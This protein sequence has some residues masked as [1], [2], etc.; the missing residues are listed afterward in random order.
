[1]IILHSFI[2]QHYQYIKSHENSLYFKVLFIAAQQPNNT[3]QYNNKTNKSQFLTLELKDFNI[4][5]TLTL[6]K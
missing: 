2:S 5:N 3:A 4:S 1:M 6:K